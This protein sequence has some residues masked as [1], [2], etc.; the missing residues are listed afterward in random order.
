[1]G[2]K[3]YQVG[4]NW[5]EEV[6]EYY[7]RYGFCTIKLP[8]DIDGTVCD[9]IALKYNKAVCIECKHIKGEKLYYE[10]SGLKHKR[11]ELDNFVANGIN[12]IIF[13]KSDKT[14]KF[15]IDW[16]EARRI[17]MEKGYITKED[18]VEVN[19]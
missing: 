17:L 15:L 6:M 5:E 14:G 2:L 11:D 7:K 9:I 3:Q 12:I 19:M 13:V 1:M 16:F 4:K 8:T 10:S 18:G